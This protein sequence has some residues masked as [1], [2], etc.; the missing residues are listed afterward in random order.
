MSG[1]GISWAICKSASRSRQITMPVPHH[2]S[3]LQAGCPSC[4]PTNS[5]KALKAEKKPLTGLIV[6][7]GLMVC[8]NRGDKY[9]EFYFIQIQSL[10]QYPGRYLC[11]YTIEHTDLVNGSCTVQYR[12]VCGF[13][14]ACNVNNEQLFLRRCCNNNCRSRIPRNFHLHCS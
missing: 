6:V 8:F 11:H 4:C 13:R 7:V 5:V 10:I 14:S 9:H 12:A 3:F 1:N 2:S